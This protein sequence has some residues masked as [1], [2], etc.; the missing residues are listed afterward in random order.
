MSQTKLNNTFLEGIINHVSDPIFVKDKHHNYIILNDAMCSFMGFPREELI[1]K[2]D[3]DFFSEEESKV[4][5]AKDKEVFDTGKININEESFTNAEG[6]HFTISTKKSLY[7]TENGDKILVGIIRDITEIK[8]A[9]IKLLSS[10]DRLGDFAHAASHDLKEP[11]RTIAGFAELLNTKHK[12]DLNAEGQEYLRFILHGAKKM[13]NLVNDILQYSKISSIERV[14]QSVN[15]DNAIAGVIETIQQI[16]DEYGAQ[17]SIENTLHNIK[18]NPSRV[19]QLFQNLIL[20]AA[21]FHKKGEKPFISIWSKQKGDE[22]LVYVSDKGIGIEKEYL[23]KIFS[24]FTRLNQ[25]HEYIGSGIGL[26]TCK[27]IV[28]QMNGK[29]YAESEIG[30]GTTIIMHL[31]IG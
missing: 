2:T 6:E 24:L 15:L 5:Y 14:P 25:S 21:K 28:E 8:N 11:L 10:I 31:P 16:I 9:E 23:N 4:F 7:V 29:I 26:A 22:I 20:N 30:V 19:Y 3:A 17:I 27:K 18:G 12:D 13:N 1:G